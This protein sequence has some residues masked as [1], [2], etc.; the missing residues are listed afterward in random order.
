MTAVLPLS[1]YLDISDC[2]TMFSMSTLNPNSVLLKNFSKLF[3]VWQIMPDDMQ[4]LCKIHEEKT[5]IYNVQMI[6][7]YGPAF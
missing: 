4:F 1:K 7:K 2:R 3:S 6:C 5:T